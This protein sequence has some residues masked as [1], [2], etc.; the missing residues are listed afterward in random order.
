VIDDE[1]DWDCA[2]E[3][4]HSGEEEEAAGGGAETVH[5]FPADEKRRTLPFVRILNDL[6]SN[7]V[8]S[9]KKTLKDNSDGLKRSRKCSLLSPRT[10]LFLC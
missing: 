6:R 9:P 10:K 3:G 1:R 8:D 7:P 5:I 4:F 2:A